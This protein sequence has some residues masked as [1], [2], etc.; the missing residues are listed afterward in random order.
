M[1]G[2]VPQCRKARKRPIPFDC[3]LNA[4]HEG[5]CTPYTL[6]PFRGETEAIIQ[7]RASGDPAAVEV[8]VKAFR[9]AAEELRWRGRELAGGKS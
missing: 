4:G 2:T 7:A 1:S 3:K 6:E 5:H 8:A 9:A